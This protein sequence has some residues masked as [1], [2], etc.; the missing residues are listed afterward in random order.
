MFT[1]W[2]QFEDQVLAFT[3]S[4]ALLNFMQKY[5]HAMLG[6]QIY[7]RYKPKISKNLS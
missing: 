2:K 5:I 3:V 7:W 6:Y 1:F 4:N